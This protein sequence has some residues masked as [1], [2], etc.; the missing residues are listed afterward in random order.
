MPGAAFGGFLIN[1]F[2]GTCGDHDNLHHRIRNDEFVDYTYTEI[3]KFD[4]ICSV[5]ACGGEAGGLHRRGGFSRLAGIPPLDEGKA[6]EQ[7]EAGTHPLALQK[8]PLRGRPN[9]YHQ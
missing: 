3:T 2:V 5:A 4:C 1:L 8:R 6:A 9:R 7:Q